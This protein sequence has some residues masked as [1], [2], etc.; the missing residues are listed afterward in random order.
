MTQRA[1]PTVWR[2]RIS[3][4]THVAALTLLGCGFHGE[5]ANDSLDSESSLRFPTV[6]L[7]PGA[8]MRV[9][10]GKLIDRCGEV[11]T[12]RGVNKDTYVDTTGASLPEIGKTAANAVRMVWTLN[13]SAYD[14][15]RVIAGALAAKLIPII[16]MHDATGDFSKLDAVFDYWTRADVAAVLIA[17][18]TDLIVNVANEAGTNATTDAVYTST[19]N[20]GIARLRAA[21]LHMPLMLDAASWGQGVEQLLRVAPSVLAAD[22]DHNVVFSWHEYS[23]GPG[24]TEETRITSVL[25]SAKGAGIALVI[26]EFAG[27]GVDNCDQPL[28]Y[29]HL[30]GEA[31][32]L[33]VGYLAWSWD[34]TNGHCRKDGASPFDMVT[35][36]KTVASLKPGWAR[37]VV[38]DHPASIA[39]T[40]VRTKWQTTRSCF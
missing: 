10:G 1:T 20:A 13:R 37:D 24:A 32:R 21:G 23:S 18:E 40:A 19:Y 39:H 7:E 33:G 9:R 12:L 17:H 15:E 27:V 26:G 29:G 3:T 35:D 2:V 8:T 38:L 4:L 22:S 6:T 11:V 25:E 14:A 34:N 5:T 16:E 28:P 36:G 30:I 31:Q